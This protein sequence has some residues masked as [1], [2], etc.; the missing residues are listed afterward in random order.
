MK[1]KHNDAEYHSKDWEMEINEKFKKWTK[2][3]RKDF[4][5]YVKDRYSVTHTRISI[6]KK[7]RILK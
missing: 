2:K 1:K 5:M 6:N 3:N 7:T 4:G